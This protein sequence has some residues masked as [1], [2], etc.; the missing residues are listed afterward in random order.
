MIS[1]YITR[2]ELIIRMH[3]CSYGGFADRWIEDMD[4]WLH[5]IWNNR[6]DLLYPPTSDISRTVL[7]YEIADHSDVVG[8]S[9]VDAAPNT[10]SFS[11]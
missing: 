5:S 8:A 11:T 1:D 10:S 9:P 3:L 7:G 4:G 6:C 2:T